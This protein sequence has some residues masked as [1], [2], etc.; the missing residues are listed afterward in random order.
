MILVEYSFHHQEVEMKVKRYPGEVIKTIDELSRQKR[1]F[2]KG[3]LID[4]WLFNSWPLRFARNQIA[5]ECLQKVEVMVS[6]RV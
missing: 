6:E 2:W 5:D 4:R 1:V 3:A